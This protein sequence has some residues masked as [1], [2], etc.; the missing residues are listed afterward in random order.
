W[1]KAINLVAASTLPDLWR[2]HFL[3]SGQL[4][5]FL[6]CRPCRLV[7]LGSG[8]GFPGLVLALLG[9]GE[10][11]LVESDARKCAFLREA[12]RI[13]AAPASLREGRIEGLSGRRYQVVTARALAPLDQ[14]LGHAAALL[15]PD[16]VALLLKG[17]RVAEE[18]TAARKAWKMQL[19]CFPSEAEPGGRVLRVKEISRV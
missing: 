18:L 8:A 17:R 9:A 6:P 11:D 3:D 2:R 7:D 5:R 16:G 13:T 10:V 19:E 1:Q 15:E 4:M 12:I 14:L